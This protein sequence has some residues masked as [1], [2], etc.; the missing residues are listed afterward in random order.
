MFL[1]DCSILFGN[2]AVPFSVFATDF[3]E[4]NL[5]PSNEGARGGAVG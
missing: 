1:F 2:L 5:V 4:L 3:S